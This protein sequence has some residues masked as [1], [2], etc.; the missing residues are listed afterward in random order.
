MVFRPYTWSVQTKK[1]LRYTFINLHK[2]E[3]NV[4]GEKDA[5]EESSLSQVSKFIT[6][7]GPQRG[8]TELVLNEGVKLQVVS[9][10]NDGGGEEEVGSCQ[11]YQV[12]L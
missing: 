8:L 9:L 3:R 12:F 1:H 11:K 4:A 2:C 6:H 5:I 7:E 10:I